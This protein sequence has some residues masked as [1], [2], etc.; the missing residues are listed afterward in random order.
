MNTVAAVFADFEETFLGGESK[1][2]STVAGRPVIDRTLE[3]LMRIPELDRR[4][5]F[6]RPRDRD[7]AAETLQRGG[8]SDD[9]DLL[10]LD[11]GQRP[12][13][14]LLRAARKW[15]LKAWRG[16]PLGTTW[17]DEYVE[18]RCV[19]QVMD[20]Y[21]CQGVLCL[22]GYQPVLDPGIAAIM[23]RRQDEYSGEAP[24]VFSQAP[25][26]LAGVLLRREIVRD[27]LEQNIPLGLL[28][29][30]RPEIARGDPIN[31]P[32]CAQID[33]DV[34]HTPGRLTGDTRRSRELLSAALSELGE[35]CDA[36]QL[37]AWWRRIAHGGPEP[38]PRE[39]EVELTTEY[40]LPDSRLR[41]PAGRI[42]P[43]RLENLAALEARARELAA[44]DDRM[45]FL[46]GHG[47]PLAHPHFAESC[48]RIR[49]AG[50]CGL[51]V[52]TPLVNLSEE[53]LEA[54][55]EHKIDLLM[56]YLDADSAETYQQIHRVDHFE[57]VLGNIE[58]IERLRRER[59]S[60]QPIVVPRITR[61][62]TTLPEM[63]QFYD[64]W[65][66]TT[67][68]AMIAGYNDYGGILPPDEL[69][70]CG[71]TIREPCRR[72][73]SRLTLLANGSV[74]LCGQDY[75][76]SA[77]VGEWLAETLSESW[78]SEGLAAA[79]RCHAGLDFSNW[80]LCQN[81]REWFRP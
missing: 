26:G 68:G 72:L 47:D 27:L 6:V 58:R 44:Y 29:S 54:L 74:V 65:I 22:N 20:H 28:L 4:C 79:R 52:G 69:L 57:Q 11:D 76:G 8:L 53:N 14:E 62:S 42:P 25:P 43:R 21:Q 16:S 45:I 71:P 23:L 61:C 18:P 33:P 1:L 12:R 32:I 39:L 37:C 17:F 78:H 35:E 80:S 48:Q 5:L 70:H 50:V 66:Q 81:C 51:A 38:L 77:P 56:V 19:A 41:P 64:R 60:P 30:Y 10:P 3:R 40:P 9:I 67:G 2:N 55:V 24:Q 36:G 13:R 34:V 46:G 75:A 63:E 31:Q 7:I 73:D 59:V 15:N 49:A